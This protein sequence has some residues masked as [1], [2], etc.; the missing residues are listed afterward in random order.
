MPE[1]NFYQIIDTESADYGTIFA[2]N[3][4]LIKIIVSKTI[5]EGAYVPYNAFDNVRT[6]ELNTQVTPLI[7]GGQHLNINV[8]NQETLK[9]A[10]QNPEKYPQLT[11]RVSGYAVRFNALTTEQQ[12]DVIS[13]TFTGKM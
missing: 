6:R 3:S 12:N 7:E 2:K 5:N 10:Q 13:R 1:V 4:T 8:L 9:D 11:I